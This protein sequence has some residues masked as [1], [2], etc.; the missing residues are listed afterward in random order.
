MRRYSPMPTFEPMFTPCLLCVVG[1]LSQ[2][3]VPRFL[4]L[5]VCRT[6]SNNMIIVH[7][8]D[9]STTVFRWYSPMPPYYLRG[10]VH[11][12]L[13]LCRRAVLPATSAAIL[14]FESMSFPPL[15]PSNTQFNIYAKRQHQ[16]GKNKIAI[17]RTLTVLASTCF[18]FSFSHDDIALLETDYMLSSLFCPCPATGR[19]AYVVLENLFSALK[20]CLFLWGDELFFSSAPLCWTYLLTLLQCLKK[21][22]P[23]RLAPWYTILFF[24]R[25]GTNANRCRYPPVSAVC[26]LTGRRSKEYGNKCRYF[27]SACVVCATLE[28]KI[29]LCE[30]EQGFSVVPKH[31]PCCWWY[32]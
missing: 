32:K 2:L 21:S 6:W 14:A 30:Q 26:E 22:R 1:Q 9:P 13:A 18:V 16:E 28:T 3:H 12:M 23:C 20:G 19:C 4:L 24:S 7:R 10:N 11:A 5:R 17:V 29:I 15:Q 25:K 31:V 8:H 27:I